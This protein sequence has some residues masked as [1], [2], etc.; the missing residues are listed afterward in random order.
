MAVLTV[1]HVKHLVSLVNVPSN[2]SWTHVL[3]LEFE[4]G[5]SKGVFFPLSVEVVVVTE[6][7]TAQK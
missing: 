6:A 2:N 3:V 5:C 7:D 1:S 4:S